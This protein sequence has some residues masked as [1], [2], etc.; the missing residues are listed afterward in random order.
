MQPAQP[1]IELLVLF[2]MWAAMMVAMMAPSAAPLVLKFAHANRRKGASRVAGAAGS[3][4][5]GYLLAWVG[6]SVPAALLQWAL[7]GAGLLS[8]MMESS[9][10]VL[11]G[12]LLATAGAFQFTSLKHACLLRCRS[13]LSFLM[14]DWREGQWGA[15]RMGL[16]H[17]AYCVGCCWL[18]MLLMFVAGV[19]NLLWAAAIAVL[20]LLE[21]VVPTGH[22]LARVA[23]AALIAVGIAFLVA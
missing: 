9:N 1:G 21:K 20:V 22:L 15:L 12:L 16:K 2:A 11:D 18:L 10:A 4:L 6:F 3:L 7:H 14:S 17:G 8:H 23:G 19:M 13:P 5:V